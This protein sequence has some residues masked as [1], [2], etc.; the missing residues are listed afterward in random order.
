MDRI[1]MKSG[2]TDSATCDSETGTSNSSSRVEPEEAGKA[3]LLE[4]GEMSIVLFV[5]TDLVKSPNRCTNRN[6]RG[7][8][9]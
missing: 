5:A 2:K 3:L 1:K 9:G 4:L 8:I 7:G 6:N